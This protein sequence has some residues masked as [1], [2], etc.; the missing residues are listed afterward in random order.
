VQWFLRPSYNRSP[1]SQTAKDGCA[2]S[3]R[4][5]LKVLNCDLRGNELVLDVGQH[6]HRDSVEL[7]EVAIGGDAEAER[8][9][10]RPRLDGEM[11]RFCGYDRLLPQVKIRLIRLFAVA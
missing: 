5:K 8:L 11:F 7:L 10:D 2:R 9:E 1:L 6:Q 3:T 4:E